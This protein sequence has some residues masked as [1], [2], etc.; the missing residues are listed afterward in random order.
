M[1]WNEQAERPR[2]KAAGDEAAT[3]ACQPA[4]RHSRNAVLLVFALFVVYCLHSALEFVLYR[5]R[6]VS[7][8]MLSDSDF[9]VFAVPN[10]LALVAYA[11]VFARWSRT[12]QMDWILRLALVLVLTLLATFFSFWGSLLIPLNTYGT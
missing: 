6:V 12:R 3:T 4:P 7:H 11:V 9:V 5:G 8:W 1:K 2:R 10:L